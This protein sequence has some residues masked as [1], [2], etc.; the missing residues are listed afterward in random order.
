[1]A[2]VGVAIINYNRLEMLKRCVQS[3]LETSG[4]VEFD[5]LVNDVGSTDGSRG[6]LEHNHGPFG[7][8]LDVIPV[9]PRVQPTPLWSYAQ[10]VN[11]CMRELVA[12][13]PETVFYYPLNNDNYV[14]PGWLSACVETFA[15]DP[16]I[17]HV[18][19]SVWYGPAFPQ[20][21]GK[22]QS[23]G[24]FFQH[25]MGGWATKSAFCGQKTV[26]TEPFDVDYC[27]FGMYRRDLFEKFGGLCEDYSPIYWDDPDWGFTLWEAGYR[28]VC[29][30]RSMIVHDHTPNP[31]GE[32]ERQHHFAAIGPN[33]EK[34]M[35][36]WKYF[37]R[38][39]GTRSDFLPQVVGV[40]Q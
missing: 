23:A 26:P 21:A 7:M 10:S 38:P 4:G 22:V 25:G 34:F 13:N 8:L 15:S 9:I 31:Y 12:R 28:V 5:L 1:M 32:P 36:K 37:L 11:R 24:A 20:M 14:Q 40:A 16:T 27:G 35:A 2:K 17:G 29:E 30:P 33:R 39:D 3:V 6:W 18:G 19:S